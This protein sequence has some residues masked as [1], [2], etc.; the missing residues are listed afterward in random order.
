M[1][2]ID[3]ADKAKVDF[4]VQVS[5]FISMN[6]SVQFQYSIVYTCNDSVSTRSAF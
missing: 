6:L 1:I 4:T 2:K 5:R 3:I